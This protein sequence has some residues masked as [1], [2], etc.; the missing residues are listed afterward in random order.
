MNSQD[1]K[2]AIR[3]WEATATHDYE[4]MLVLFDSKRYSDCLFFG[5]IVLEK[6]LK[7]L[8]VKNTKEQ[9]PFTHDLARLEQ[10]AGLGLSKEEVELLNNMNEFNL[11]ARY[12]EYK[13]AFYEKC[14]FAYTKTYYD[15]TKILYTK[16]CQ[17]MK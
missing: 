14:D 1:I 7:G 12:P 3:Y 9:A 16:L 17:M 5:H 2:N 11:R 15:H 6:L 4:T 13:L 10:I 8:V